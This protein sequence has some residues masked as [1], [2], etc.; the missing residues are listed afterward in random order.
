MTDL[1]EAMRAEFRQSLPSIM[2]GNDPHADILDTFDGYRDLLLR[3]P[4]APKPPPTIQVIQTIVANMA[5]VSLDSMTQR[6]KAGPHVRARWVA[7]FIA[8][9]RYGYSAGEIGRRFR[10]DHTTVL[11]GLQQMARLSETD[12]ELRDLIV[13]SAYALEDRA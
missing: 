10:R 4:S 13:R 1:I 2:E 7:M 12:N 3:V 11:Y 9:K 6:S 8:N 5:G